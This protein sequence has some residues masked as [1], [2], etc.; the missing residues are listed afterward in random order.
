MNE[1][2]KGIRVVNEDVIDVNTNVPGHTHYEFRQDVLRPGNLIPIDNLPTG[3][4]KPEEVRQ[5]SLD[6]INF[7][8]NAN[9]LVIHNPTLRE[10][11]LE[12]GII[13]EPVGVGA[14][15]SDRR[16][17]KTKSS[18]TISS[19]DLFY[20]F[21][22]LKMIDTGDK[23]WIEFHND[24]LDWGKQHDPD[25][26]EKYSIYRAL[27]DRGFVV[28][29]AANY[30]Y[31]FAVYLENVDQ[32]QNKKVKE[33]GPIV[34]Q[35]KKDSNDLSLRDMVKSI[36]LADKI[37]KDFI[38]MKARGKRDSEGHLKNIS[39]DIAVYMFDGDEM[40]IDRNNDTN[41][42]IMRKLIQSKSYNVIDIEIKKERY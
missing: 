20:A 24:L 39:D 11:F 14:R 4:N 16:F 38:I 36:K 37:Q 5:I 41:A 23:N 30:G 28:L 22:E 10:N 9:Y 26:I 13:G 34:V 31:D 1:K 42:I 29:D 8:A 17:E 2:R 3:R 21:D 15:K 33:H 18:F 40:G 19:Y 32:F 35:L 6:D 12:A 7:D 27:R 25:F